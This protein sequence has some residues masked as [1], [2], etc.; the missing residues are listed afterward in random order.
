MFSAVH[1]LEKSFQMMYGNIGLS[2]R[3]TLPFKRMV[4]YSDLSANLESKPQTSQF[5]Y[6]CHK[7]KL[8]RLFIVPTTYQL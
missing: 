8:Y 3:W 6:W 4:F 7:L 5:S 2:F 1:L